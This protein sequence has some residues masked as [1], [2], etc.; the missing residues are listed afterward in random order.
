MADETKLCTRCGT[1]PVIRTYR[2]CS[3]CKGI[4]QREMREARYL[5]PRPGFPRD[6]GPGAEEERYET[7]YGFRQ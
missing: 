3:L 7:K 5:T 2:F 1:R 6:R 4:V